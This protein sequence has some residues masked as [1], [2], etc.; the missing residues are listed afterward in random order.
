MN[1]VIGPDECVRRLRSD[2]ERMATCLATGDLAAPVA[3]CPGWDLRRLGQ[4]LAFIHRWAAH[5]VLHR[6]P[7]A[8]DTIAE[9][10]PTASGSDLA[11]W[12][13]AG[14]DALA[15]LLA[16]TP[17]DDPT[18]HP[19][20]VEQRAW[21]WSRRQM[22]ETAVHRW[23]AEVATTG[24]SDLDP[25]LAVTGITEYLE[26]GLPRVLTGVPFP[27]PSLHIHCTDGDLPSGAGEWIVWTD[28]GEYRLAAEHR[29][30]DAALRGRAADLL[31]VLMGRAERST[32]DIVGDPAAAGAWLDLP[33]W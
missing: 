32:I 11:D 23:D 20:T 15:D 16:T 31:L 21:V 24:N 9:P 5:A 6:E 19:F 26:L 14:A 10:E 13:R 3:A 4:H 22:M 30:G 17:P 1:A 33:G 8:A 25:L 7:P 29:K 2:A 12:L 18:W 27:A 28:D